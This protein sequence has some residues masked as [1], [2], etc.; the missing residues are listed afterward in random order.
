MNDSPASDKAAG[1]PAAVR[2]RL[3]WARQAHWPRIV[4][5]HSLNLLTHARH[6][7]VRHLAKKDSA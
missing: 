4:T 1:R 2:D 5:R 7:I 3:S 6:L